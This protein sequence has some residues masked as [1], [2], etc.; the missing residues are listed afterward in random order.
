[1]LKKNVVLK[2][3]TMVCSI[4]VLVCQPPAKRRK[5]NMCCFT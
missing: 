2:I 1:M 5:G 4:M 3:C